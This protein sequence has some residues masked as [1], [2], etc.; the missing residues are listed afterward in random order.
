VAQPVFKIASPE[1]V[2]RL[3]VTVAFTIVM[4]DRG[5]EHIRSLLLARAHRL[6]KLESST[7]RLPR[8]AEEAL[9]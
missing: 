8:E 7:S 5:L 6:V 4:S 9:I 2:A 3:L 1:G